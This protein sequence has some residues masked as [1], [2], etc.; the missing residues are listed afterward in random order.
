MIKVLKTFELTDKD[1]IQIENGFNQSFERNITKERLENLYNSNVFGYS[2]HSICYDQDKIIGFTSI[3]P[4]KYLKENQ[5]FIAGISCSTFILKKYRKDAFLYYDM[6]EL[7]KEECKKNNIS[8]ILGVPNKFSHK[9]GKVFLGAKDVGELPYY[10]LPLRLLTVLKLY[11]FKFFDNYIV[12]YFVCFFCLINRIISYIF[13]SK[14]KMSEYRLL[15]TDDFYKARFSAPHYLFS[16]K[17]NIKFW[18]RIVVEDN[19]R[20]AYLMDF[21]ENETRTNKA[22]CVATWNIIM[23]E[24]VDVILYIGTLR[25]KQGLLLKIPSKFVPKTLPF[26]YNILNINNCQQFLSMSDMKLWDFGL[27]NFD[28]R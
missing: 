24:H 16:S 25:M 5:V 9:Y 20:A 17:K 21:R 6:I 18:Y 14:E 13:N 15:N 23:K 1:W 11:Q 8:V 2:Y 10:I 4:S 7:V 19:I 22:L 26:T 28:V 12:F 3:L 27:M